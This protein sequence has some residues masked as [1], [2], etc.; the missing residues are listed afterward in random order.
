MFCVGVE[1][2]SRDFEI[3]SEQGGCDIIV[4]AFSCGP[5]INLLSA[6]SYA[7]ETVKW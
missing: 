6:L 7:V 4:V 5:L 2:V 1:E 3:R